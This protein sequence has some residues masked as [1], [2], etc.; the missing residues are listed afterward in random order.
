MDRCD[1]LASRGRVVCSHCCIDA[2]VSAAGGV[3]LA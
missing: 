2:R 1:S 3:L